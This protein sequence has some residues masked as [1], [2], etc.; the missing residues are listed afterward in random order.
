MI[1]VRTFCERH[2]FMTRPTTIAQLKFQCNHNCV[3]NLL[4]AIYIC[5]FLIIKPQLPQ[6]PVVCLLYLSHAPVVDSPTCLIH[7]SSI[8]LSVLLTCRPSTYLARLFRPDVCQPTWFIH[9]ESI[10]VSSVKTLVNCNKNIIRFQ[11]D[12]N[13]NMH[14]HTVEVGEWLGQKQTT[15][16]RID[17]LR[18][19]CLSLL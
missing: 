9:V 7:L 4:T 19:R 6:P 8:Y 2:A 17:P 5:V 15:T 16:G 1:W 13:S 11:F 10:H 3:K 14:T 12:S 18:F